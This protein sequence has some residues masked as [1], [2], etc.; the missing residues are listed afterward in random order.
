MSRNLDLD[1]IRTFVAVADSGSMTVAANLLHMT[2]G[3]VSQQVKRLEEVLD[4]LLFVRKTRRLEL[5]RQGEQFLVKARKLL[6][7]NDE[8]WA[9]MTAQP[10]RGALRVGVPYDLVT[11]LAP[12]M[13]AFA[14]AHPHVEITLTC[15]ASSE[16]SEA[17]KSGR[18]DVSLV[19]Y[20]ASEAEGEVVCIEPL[21]WVKGRGSEA[22]QKRPLPLSMVDERCAFRPVVL[23]ALA[24]EGI[25]WRTVFESGNIEATA[26][27]VRAG[28]AVTSWLASTVPADLETLAPRVSGLPALPPF[29][30]CLRLPATVQPAA[31]EFARHVRESMSSGA[32]TRRAPLATIA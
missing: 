2:Q 28:L 3:A 14:D 31:Q 8:I 1:L 26:A 12:A 10:L 30:I 16:L 21:V 6:R 18:L 32:G 23:G 13:K 19:E 9:D 4:C 25:A 5:S 24:D 7:L 27:T 11:R 29:A 15:A 20:V 17:V 22:W